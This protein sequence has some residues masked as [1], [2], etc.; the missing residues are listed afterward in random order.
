MSKREFGDIEYMKAFVSLSPYILIG[1]HSGYIYIKFKENNDYFESLFLI[2]LI[3]IVILS[4]G[5]V[6][7]FNNYTY[8]LPVLSFCLSFI[9]EKRLQSQ[10]HLLLS[11][12]Y[13]PIFSIVIL[14]I[15]YLEMFRIE[16]GSINIDK[17]ISVSY[18]LALVLW[19]VISFSFVGLK[20]FPNFETDKR[21]YFF[22]LIKKFIKLIKKGFLINIS[23]II[24]SG[25]LFIDRFY[26]KEYNFEFLPVYSLAFNFAQIV[27]I[28]INTLAYSSLVKIG[29]DLKII[30]KEYVSDLLKHSFKMFFILLLVSFFFV[31]G[32]CLFIKKYDYLIEVYAVISIFL[33]AY[34]TI[35]I[36][37]PVLIYFDK[38]LHSTFFL[39]LIFFSSLVISEFLVEKQ[40]SWL[41]ILIKSGILLLLSAIYNL[42]LIFK[43]IESING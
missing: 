30:N 43:K 2:G 24:L 14:G 32:Y 22:L 12:L 8:F 19:I 42:F 33:G 39:G 36:V 38:M 40:F 21:L 28:G 13:K 34:Y 23:T 31:L 17:T 29:E 35:S 26:V 9:F 16:D 25:Y 4:I 11:V 15:V 37:T 20:L 3:N 18:F 6:I 5:Y 27:F 10:N 7:Y 41:T 1:S